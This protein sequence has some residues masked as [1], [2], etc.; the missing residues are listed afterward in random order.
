MKSSRVLT[1]LAGAAAMAG[2][3][4][5]YGAVVNV[6][7]PTN[8]VGTAPSAAG[9]AIN[10]SIDLNG[11]GQRD[12]YIRYRDIAEPATANTTGGTLLLSYI[13]MGTSTAQGGV[14]GGQIAT[15]GTPAY[16]T[17]AFS[18]AQGT[19]VG[20]S[21]VFYQTSGYLS[22]LVTNYKGTNYGFTDYLGKAG[23]AENV[24]FKFL[25]STGQTD[26]GYIQ[27]AT[28]PYV[29]AANPGGIK[30]LGLAYDNSG[31]AITIPAI[32][33]GVPEPGTLAALAVGAA[34]V[35]GVGLKRR[36]AAAAKA[37]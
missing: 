23:V 14:Y 6:T 5:A 2:A 36:R 18:L 31:A 25:T 29:S 32:P 9:T 15:G 10:R 19:S 1:G 24:G 11:D 17:Y 12:V 7:L 27:L 26:Y 33:A 8:I 37:Q 35:A 30:F 22:H 21:G 4:Q 20:S 16:S 3:S 13:Y 28:D 34:A